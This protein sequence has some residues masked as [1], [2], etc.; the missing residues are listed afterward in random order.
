M[1]YAFY[2]GRQGGWRGALDW[3]IRTWMHGPYSHVEAIIG[4]NGDLYDIASSLP[5]TGVRIALGQVL[6]PKQWDIYDGPGDEATAL[7]WFKAHAGA[8]Y[9]YLGLFG[10]VW[11]PITGEKSAYF[12]S[13]SCC[14]AA[15]ILEPWR[16][17][18]NA[19]ADLVR[20]D[21]QKEIA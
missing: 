11:R 21:N 20:A 18:P 6:S 16:F 9:N 15:D 3:A 7:A 12:C 17:D 14:Y 10:F 13:E 4:Q 8:K 1:R 5:G 19:L 2:K